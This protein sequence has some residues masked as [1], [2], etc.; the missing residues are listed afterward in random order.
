MCWMFLSGEFPWN[1]NNYCTKVGGNFM[2]TTAAN[3]LKNN[4]VLHL[5]TGK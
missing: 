2:W 3:C 5:Y 4:S 1:E